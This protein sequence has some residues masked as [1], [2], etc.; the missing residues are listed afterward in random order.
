[1]KKSQTSPGGIDEYISQCP[2]SVR[3]VLERVRATIRRAAP[4]ATETI[5][6][7]MPTFVLGEKS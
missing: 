3:D 6:Y 1:V 4:D 5:K 2:E 7:R